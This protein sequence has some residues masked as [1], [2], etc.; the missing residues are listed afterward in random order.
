VMLPG[1]MD[2]FSVCRKIRESGDGHRDV[3]VLMLSA[4]TDKRSVV[5]GLEVGADDYVTKPFSPKELVSRVKAHLRRRR[6]LP[7]RV[8]GESR[9][10]FPG[11]IIDLLGREVISEGKSVSL[12][13]REF[14]ILVLLA[15]SPGRVFSRRQIMDHLWGGD[16]Y[17]E[18]RSADVHAHHIRQKIEPHPS[19]PRYL[20]TVRNAGYKFS[21]DLNGGRRSP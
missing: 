6:D 19:H 12:T 20:L 15:S 11:L 17:G 8:Q 7:G 16:F 1:Q 21:G 13:A 18:E 5:M 4:R 14:E 2:G 9:L 10:E 3:P